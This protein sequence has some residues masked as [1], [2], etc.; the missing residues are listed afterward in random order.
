MDSEIILTG[1]KSMPARGNQIDQLTQ[2]YR[3]VTQVT[4]THTRTNTRDK[5]TKKATTVAPRY[6]L[7]KI[8]KRSLS[9]QLAD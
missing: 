1:L 4:H 6:D 9:L 7:K 3:Q 5:K 8:K 2:F